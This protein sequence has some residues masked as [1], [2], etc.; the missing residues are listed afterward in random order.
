MGID[1]ARLGRD[2]RIRDTAHHAIT[3]KSTEISLPKGIFRVFDFDIR[4][5]SA[6]SGACYTP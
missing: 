1:K 3:L 4:D 2:Y 5:S 6:L